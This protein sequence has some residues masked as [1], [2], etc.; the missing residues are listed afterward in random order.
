VTGIENGIAVGAQSGDIDAGAKTDRDQDRGRDPRIE[1]QTTTGAGDTGLDRRT[2][3]TTRG[4]LETIAE[5]GIGGEEI[6]LDR[7]SVIRMA[8]D[9]GGRQAESFGLRDRE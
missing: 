5:T 9:A 6:G 2:A 1:M 7:E 8:I 3:I 4:D